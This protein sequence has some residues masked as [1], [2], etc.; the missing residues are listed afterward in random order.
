M[1]TYTATADPRWLEFLSDNCLGSSGYHGNLAGMRKLY[2]GSSAPVIRCAGYLFRVSP[3]IF[4]KVA[5]RFPAD[6]DCETFVASLIMA[7]T[8]GREPM[9]AQE[10]AYNLREWRAEGWE[11]IPASLTPDLFA[12][13]WNDGIIERS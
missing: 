11:D 2:W 8:E 3:E 12:A 7:S 13:I 6:N 10:A 1:S 4:R 5:G 9:T